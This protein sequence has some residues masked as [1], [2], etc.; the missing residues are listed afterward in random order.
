MPESKSGAL[1][2]LAMGLAG[3]VG[4]A[5]PFSGVKRISR[6]AHK[7]F[8]AYDDGL[9]LS[10]SCLISK[11]SRMTS[12]DAATHPELQEL[13]KLIDKRPHD[14][15]IKLIAEGTDVSVH[16]LRLL[17]RGKIPDPSFNRVMRVRDYLRSH[18]KMPKD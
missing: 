11:V 18:P 15:T 7:I 5:C 9:T 4:Y 6:L 2:R 17:I 10:A 12:L 3:C 1:D 13:L 16:W 8:T 14:V